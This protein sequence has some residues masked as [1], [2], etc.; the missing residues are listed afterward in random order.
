MTG[1]A[2]KFL[3]HMIANA[4]YAVAILDSQLNYITSSS[5]WA[6]DYEQ[7]FPLMGDQWISRYYNA[8]H[9]ENSKGEEKISLSDGLPQWLHWE[10]QSWV[11]DE[12]EIGGLMLYLENFTAVKEE[13]AALQKKLD[14]YQQT[15]EAARIGAWELDFNKKELFWSPVT[16]QIYGMPDDYM[17]GLAAAIDLFKE[18]PGKVELVKHFITAVE[19]GAGYDLELQVVTARGE[20]LWVRAKAA[21]EFVD[22]ACIRIYG[23]FQDIQQQKLQE[24]Q[25]ANSELK[26]RSLIENSLYA[27]LLIIPGGC[28]I[29]AN[30]SAIDMFGYTLEEFR[31]VR[32]HDLLDHNHPNFENFMLTRHTVG[33]VNAELTGIRKNGEYFPCQISATI[34]TDSEGVIINNLVIVDMSERQRADEQMRLS[35]EQFRGAFENSAIGM[36]LFD[37]D[38]NCKRANQSLCDMLGYTR[39]EFIGIS[40]RDITYSDDLPMS[41]ELIGTL[42]S[43]STD[44]F[45]LEKRYLHKNGTLVWA[46]LGIS[47][48]KD[49]ANHPLHFITQMQDIT[50]HKIAENLISEE[51][52]LLRTLIDNLPISIYIK[53][54]D[55]KR[56]MVNQSEVNYMERDEVNLIGK[57]DF[58]LFPEEFAKTWLQED[59]KVLNTGVPMIS[60]ETSDIKANGSVTWLLTSKIPLRNTA[61]EIIGL[62]GI[63]YD[64]TKI[65]EAEHA[66]AVS[67]EKYREIFENIQDIY[68]RNDINGVVMEISPSVEKHSGYLRSDIIGKQ[69]TDFYYLKEDREK[70]VLALKRDQAVTD[71]EVILVSSNSELVYASVNAR[72]IIQNGIVVGSEGSIRDITQRKVQENELTMLNTELKAINKHREKLLSV[73]GHDLRNPVAA[74]LKLAELALMDIDDTS[75]DELIEYLT[76]MKSGLINANELLEDLLHWATNQFNSLNFNPV[77]ISDLQFH[78]ATCLERMKPMAWEKGIEV[79]QSVEKG[80]SIYADKDM[81]DGVLRNLVSN[82]IKFTS[83]GSIT[84]AAQ[85]RQNDVLF[86]VTDTGSGIPESVIAKLFNKGSSYTTYGTSGEKGTGLGLELCRDFVEKHQGRIWIESKEGRGSTFYF[87]IPI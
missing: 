21:T 6:A 22:G 58:D 29:E 39:E 76:K 46:M 59:Q 9:G 54:K 45:Y 40:V 5:R 47:V 32:R 11:T 41:L 20:D 36:A 25:T 84:V 3:H 42:T 37:I 30:Q 2:P 63:N 52:K 73:I 16:K 10:V 13:N 49:A 86:S 83:S 27:F 24:I 15:N 79:I 82:A 61:D 35:E 55:F 78:I 48:V 38:G 60:K 65:K 64:I 53:D 28:V 57:T 68:Y 66:L 85:S 71:F 17:P 12:G 4:P 74:S 51:R 62:L 81:L 75:K 70:I 26:Y 67:E 23:T 31:K 18:G 43:G 7:T 19:T 87:T 1:Y 69:V 50:E 80:L 34:Y 14:L 72:L 44:N 77:P 56:T 33:K 8:L